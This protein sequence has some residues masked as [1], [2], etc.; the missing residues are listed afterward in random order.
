M[1][2]AVDVQSST[3]AVQNGDVTILFLFARENLEDAFRAAGGEIPRLA[4]SL[5][6][7][8]IPDGRF[9]TTFFANG[10]D[11]GHLL[12]V[13]GGQRSSLEPIVLL[14]LAATASRYLT[15]RGFSSL[16]YVE[17]LDVDGAQFAHAAVEGA[18]RGTYDPG[19]RKTKERKPRS[20]ER[21]TVA[22][23]ADDTSEMSRAALMGQ[24]VGEASCIAR[25]LVN[26]PPNNLTP[27]AFAERARALSEAEGLQY[28]VLDE[29]DMERLG[30]GAILGVAAGSDLPP[31]L[32]SMRYGDP[33]SPIKLALVGKGITFD[34]GGLAIK[35]AAGMETMKGDMGGGA[36][37]VAGMVAVARLAPQNISV[38]GYVGTTENMIN[39]RAMRPGDVLT[40]LTGETIEV[41]NP[42]AE[43][44]LVLADV[45]AHA[46]EQGA[47]HL[48][49]FATLTGAAAVALGSA[50]SLAAG[51]PM[52]WVSQVMAAAGTGLERSWAMPLYDDY[53][54]NMDSSVADIKNTGP[55]GG[56]ALNAAAFLADFVRDVPWT[57]VDIAGTSWSED[58]KP[59]CPK[60]GTGVGVGTIAALVRQLA[61]PD[62]QS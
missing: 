31:R 20:L 33:N 43:G 5:P 22:S 58:V 17:P 36:A 3:S 32:F 55:R 54:R 16:C 1:T 10:G 13:G 37:V 12:V 14:R 53:R 61:G 46:V 57:H 35:P 8:S 48:V 28:S 45:L 2:L 18:V 41:L 62:S 56:G 29:A 40:A 39:G 19:L 50:C 44:R 34:S 25:D 4:S 59:Y 15:S 24:I 49:D 38:T 11:G 47:T 9:E 21:V 30:M 26:M 23:H 42:D 27:E 52:D 51:K 60:G 6:S 7:G